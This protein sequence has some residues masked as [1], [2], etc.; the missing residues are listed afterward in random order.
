M[1]TDK[2]TVAN[3]FRELGVMLEIKGENP[4]K[5][6]AYENAAKIIEKLPENLEGLARSSDLIRID[7]IGP[8]IA[9]KISTIIE[10]GGLPKLDE[11]RASIPPELIRMLE[12][13][14]LTPHKI[15]LLWKKLGITTVAEL[16]DA[17][18]E[19]RLAELRGFGEESQTE[20]L[21]YFGE[22][23]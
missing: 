23:G 11:V 2:T 16:K 1:K 3:M 6:R 7:G 20:I 10:T 18:R 17:C 4:F 9:K 15:N 19:N 13:P 5:I 22:K 12:I 14:G 21:K 8:A